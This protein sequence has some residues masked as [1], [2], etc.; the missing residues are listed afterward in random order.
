MSPVHARRPG[1]HCSQRTGLIRQSRFGAVARSRLTVRMPRSVAMPSNMH[2]PAFVG[3]TWMLSVS[4]CACVDEGMPFASQLHI[5]GTNDD[6]T[7]AAKC[8]VPATWHSVCHMTMPGTIH[9]SNPCNHLTYARQPLN[10][11]CP[12][13]QSHQVLSGRPCAICMIVGR[14]MWKRDSAWGVPAH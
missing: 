5:C 8:P 6:M 4:H 7:I 9:H 11:R 12:L 3:C 14:G 10:R 1:T 2:E 13:L